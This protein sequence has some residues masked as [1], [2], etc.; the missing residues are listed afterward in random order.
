M[1][2]VAPEANSITVRRLSVLKVHRNNYSQNHVIC[3]E[4]SVI[5]HTLFNTHVKGKEMSTQ[6]QAS[7]M[8]QL[9]KKIKLLS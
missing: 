4:S 3:E 7:H 9:L 2:D 6:S 8:T 1:F 5:D